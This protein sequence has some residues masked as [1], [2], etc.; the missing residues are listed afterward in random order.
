MQF[1]EREL[2]VIRLAQQ[3]ARGLTEHP[4]W[5][6][7]PPV[8]PE[9]IAEVLSD[10]AAAGFARQQARAELKASARAKQ[11]ALTRLNRMLRSSVMYVQ[12]M[13]W[14]D[15]AR[16]FH[17]G[18]GPRRRPTRNH[19]EAP[20]QT[21]GLTALQHGPTWVVL[22]WQEPFDG[23]PVAAYRVERD[24]KGGHW[25]HVG[26]SVDTTL[27]LENQEPGV[28]LEFR[29]VGVNSAGDGPP[30]NSVRVVL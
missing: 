29:V 30:S 21:V 19:L 23:G 28:A 6:P 20:G 27:R 16:L 17:V 11:E 7:A 9:E 2:E 3:M 25:A 14:D 18:W 22:A 1:P 4:D 8:A 26:T 24:L 10:Y 15:A 12:S 5:Y 13:A